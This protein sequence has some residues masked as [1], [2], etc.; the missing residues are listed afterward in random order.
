M[1]RN[2]ISKEFSNRKEKYNRLGQNITDALKTFLNEQAIPY[3]DIYFRVRKFDSFYEKIERKKYSSPF[4][5]VEDICGIRVICYYNSDVDRINSIIKKE[6]DILEDLNKSEQLSPKE[7]AY[8]SHHFIVKTN[9]DWQSAP[10]YRNLDNYKAEIQVR[11]IL[12]HAWAEIE[13]KLNYK[14]DAQ[15]PDKFQRKLFRLSA[16]FEEADEQFE[17]LRLGIEEY[18]V[19]INSKIKE[20]NNFDLSQDFNIESFKAFINFKFQEEEWSDSQLSTSF[21][22]FSKYEK[23][24]FEILSKSLD[25]VYPHKDNILADL[26]DANYNISMFPDSMLITWMALDIIDHKRFQEFRGDDSG[27]AESWAKVRKIWS[28]KIK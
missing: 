14:N 26:T 24:A 1:N 28:E 8:R 3:L 10:N 20:S 22:I 21:D 7:F 27:I 16:K 5:E 18:K 6:F 12:M 19:D 4:D 11:T 23:K 15:V 9:K 17:E 25:K 13:H 2:E